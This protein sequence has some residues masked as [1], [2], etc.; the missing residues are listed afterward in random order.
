MRHKSYLGMLFMLAAFSCTGDSGNN[1]LEGTQWA[2]STPDYF[3]FRTGSVL[4]YYESFQG[5]SVCFQHSVINY[6]I[7]GDS[8][9]LSAPPDFDVRA[10]FEVIGDSLIFYAFD[11]NI[12]LA[13]VS[14]SP[15]TLDTCP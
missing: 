14:F 6:I 10:R 9:F 11:G 2:T 4:D 7:E 5:A 13:K 8:V 12:R 15:D 1:P 3:D